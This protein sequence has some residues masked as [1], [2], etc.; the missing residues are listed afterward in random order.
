MSSPDSAAHDAAHSDTVE[1]IARV[2]YA[3]KGVLYFLI[4]VLAV[5]AAF[6]SGGKTAGSRGAIRSIAEAPFG[7]VLLW[8]V[9]LGLAAYALWRFVQAFLDPDD[10]GSSAEGITKRFGYFVSG[11][12]HA[13]LTFWLVRGLLTAGGP[14]SAGSGGQRGSSGGGGSGGGDSG[15]GASDWTATLMEQ[16]FGPWLV[17][18]AGAAVVGYGLYQLYKAAT[19]DSSEKFKTDEMS[20]TEEK[21]ARVAGQ[22]GLGARGVVFGMIG[23]FLIYAA[24]TADPSEARG[25]GGALDTLAAQPFGPYLLGAVALGLAAYGVYCGINARY[26]KIPSG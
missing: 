15:G 24:W 16:P 20:E 12:I 17:G 14:D 7:Q 5:M 3:V 4:G 1:N 18:I 25:L 10:K 26:R 6:G 22:A 2:G 11:L 21:V 23:G 8:V 9:A 13:G 19:V